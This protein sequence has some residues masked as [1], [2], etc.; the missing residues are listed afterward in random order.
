MPRTSKKN[1]ALLAALDIVEETGSVAAVTYDSLS[2]ATGMTKSG[3]I[4]HFPDRHSLLVAMHAFC[5][6]RWEDELEALAKGDAP[7]DRHR[8]LVLSLSKNDPVVELL[9]SI[10][11]QTHPDFAAPW[12]AV[13]RRWMPDPSAPVE[14]EEELLTLVGSVLGA[15]LWVHDHIMETHLSVENRQK[16]IGYMLKL[17][18]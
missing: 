11:A 17:L 14:T 7:R 8:A 9:M 18:S 10:H 2:Q 6:R 5:A 15:G 16:I 1:E 13:N 12:E 3:L 4:Y